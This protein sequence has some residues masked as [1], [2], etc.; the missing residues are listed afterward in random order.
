[1]IVSVTAEEYITEIAPPFPPSQEQLL[2]VIPDSV[3]FE[4]SD[5]NSNTDP[6]PFCRVISQN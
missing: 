5:A 3:R 1:M 6:F 4:L 2:N